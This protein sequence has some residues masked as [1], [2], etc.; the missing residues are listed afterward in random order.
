MI[1]LLLEYLVSPG[2]YSEVIGCV[3]NKNKTENNSQAIK[4]ILYCLWALLHLALGLL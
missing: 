3:K 4:R 2:V 1:N